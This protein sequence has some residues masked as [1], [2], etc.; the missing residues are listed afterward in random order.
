MSKRW[1]ITILR[2]KGQYL[3]SVEAPNAD[4]AIKRAVERLGVKQ[5]TNS[6]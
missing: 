1:R 4:A 3:G 6:G 2:V 5:R